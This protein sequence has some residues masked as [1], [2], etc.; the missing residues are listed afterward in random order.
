MSVAPGG[1]GVGKGGRRCYLR[2]LVLCI[3][4]WADAAAEDCGG[5]EGGER[6]RCEGMMERLD[7]TG[8]LHDMM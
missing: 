1:G 4:E 5:E 3:F 2:G 8:D 6:R 7:T